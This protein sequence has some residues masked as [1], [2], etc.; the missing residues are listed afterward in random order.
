MNR[1]V[2]EAIRLHER[3]FWLSLLLLAGFGLRL[4]AMRWPPFPIDMGD[5]IVWG[6]R[7]LAGGPANFYSDAIFADYA[8][9]YVYV[10][11][12]TAAIKNGLFP[13]AG[14]ET[15]HFLYR[16]TPILIDLA[17]A[18]LIYQ[19]VADQELRLRPR[20]TQVEVMRCAASPLAL[21]AA[22]AHLFNPAIIFNSAVW[23]QIDSTFTFGMLLS[24]VL[25]ER[26]RAEWAVASYVIAFMIKPQAISLAPVIGLF[27]LLRYPPRRWLAAAAV[28]L[29]L[30]YLISAPFLG[31][32][33]YGRL[34]NLLR[35]SVETY[36]YTSLFTYNLWA[37]YGMWQDDTVP[38]RFGLSVRTTG[39]LLYLVGIAYG[40]ALLV[41]RLR[42]FQ[43]GRAHV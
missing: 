2:F 17:S 30:G 21:L 33:A 26:G 42:H 22:A 29:A 19:L 18:V 5:W 6:E 35:K 32:N 9:G 10:M 15:Y 12:L 40:A 27:L 7:V 20:R 43:I 3:R 34:V 11:W 36:P 41:R 38:F 4:W 14:V 25:L 24:L 28:G 37:L 1:W 8:P 16:L 31:F 13:T 39:T 23:G